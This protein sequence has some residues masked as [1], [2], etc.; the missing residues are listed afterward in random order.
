MVEHAK[1]PISS[2]L[3]S[4]ANHE[5]SPKS[6]RV[7]HAETSGNHNEDILIPEFMMAEP[8]L[9]EVE[10][11][12]GYI[13]EDRPDFARTQLPE[14]NQRNFN[15]QHHGFSFDNIP[16]AKWRDKI[17]EMH[18]WCTEQLLY[19]GTSFTSVFDKLVARFHGRLRQWWIS[20]GQYRQLQMRQSTSVDAFIGHIHN[21]FLGTWEHYTVQAREEYL[22]MK[23]CSF[24]RK[25]LEKHYAR[26][27]KRFYAI[28]GL[29]DINLK[30]A[31]LKSLPEPLG[32]ETS[33][34]L[35]LKNVA[36]PQASLGEIY[37]TSLAALDKL[38]N[39]KKIFKQLHEQGKLLGKACE[40]P[41]LSIK[42]KPKKCG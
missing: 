8:S 39:H 29:D 13:S 20:L 30:Q 2:F 35:S 3:E 15:D 16:P 32:N 17:Y 10:S 38:C 19:P 14:W 27:S 36:L 18:A 40:R 21:E 25:D 41:D 23:C 28:N 4:A 24:R 9:D 1:N 37:Q 26:M 31:F 11:D 7:K 6:T 5:E 34:L 33:R 12:A 42:C 22:N